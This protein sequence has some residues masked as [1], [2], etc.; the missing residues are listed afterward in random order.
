MRNNPMLKPKRITLT[1]ALAMLLSAF[2]ASTAVSQVLK[3]GYVDNERI[4]A[5]Y[6]DWAKAQEEFETQYRA[7]DDE[8]R[9]MQQELEDLIEEYE[10]QKLILS[11]EKKKERELTIETKRQALDAFTKEIFGPNGTAERK[12]NAMAKPLLEN[13]NAAIERLANEGNY[14]FIFNVEGLAYAKKDY[15]VTD[16][17]LEFLEEE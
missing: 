12:N 17:V 5:E 9:E 13:I 10:N 16:K 14:D 2:L 11:E 1:L 6:K 7:W 8:A 4:F 3:I 15:D